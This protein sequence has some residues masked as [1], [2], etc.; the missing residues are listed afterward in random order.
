MIEGLEAIYLK[1][2]PALSLVKLKATLD[3]EGG[4]LTRTTDYL[5][6]EGS[7]G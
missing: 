6:R 2:F 7:I 1:D 4:G 5:G 3:V